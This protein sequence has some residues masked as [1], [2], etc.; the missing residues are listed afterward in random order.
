MREEGTQGRKLAESEATALLEQ[1]CEIDIGEYGLQLDDR[2]APL[3]RFTANASE[4]RATGGWVKRA[5]IAACQEVLSEVPIR[6]CVLACLCVARG[7]M[8]WL[9]HETERGGASCMDGNG[10]MKS[11][12]VQN[13][14]L[15]LELCVSTFGSM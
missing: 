5:L 3:P 15:S 13:E 7:S 8:L 11:P 14:A 6:A 10:M 12:K 2:G 4:N 9:Q 1:F